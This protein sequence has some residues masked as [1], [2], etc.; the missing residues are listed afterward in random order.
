MIENLTLWAEEKQR[1]T[2]GYALSAGNRNDEE[3]CQYWLGQRD[4]FGSLIRH[5]KSPILHEDIRA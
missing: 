2:Y 3:A 5:L 4:A 1:E